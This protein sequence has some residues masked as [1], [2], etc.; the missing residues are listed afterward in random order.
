MYK[1]RGYH[2]KTGVIE[3]YKEPLGIVKRS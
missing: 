3:T 1:E 2:N